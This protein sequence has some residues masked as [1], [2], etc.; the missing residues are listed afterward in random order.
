MIL[1]NLFCGK[2]NKYEK[3]KWIRNLVIAIVILL[4]IGGIIYYVVS[5]AIAQSGDVNIRWSDVV[6]TLQ[7]CAGYIW[8]IGIAV[9]LA[10]VICIACRKLKKQTRFMVRA[11][12][13][14]AAAQDWTIPEPTME[15]Y[16]ENGIFESAEE[17]SDTALI[18]LSRS[19]GE[20]ADL[21]RSITDENTMD[22]GEYG[23]QVVYT[24][25][26]DDVDPPRHYLEL[27]HREEEMVERVTSEFSNVIVIA[28]TNNP[29]E[30]GWGNEADSIKSVLWVAGTGERGFDALGRILNGEVNPSGKLPDTYVY[31]NLAN[32][33]VSNYGDFEYENMSDV[34][35]KE[36]EETWSNDLYASFVNYT[37][38]IYVGYRFY[39][40]AAAEGLID[41]DQTVL[42][43]FGYGLSYTTIDKTISSIET[44]GDTISLTVTV[45]NTGNIAGKD[46]V[47]IYYTPPYYN[48]GIEKSE[49]NLVQFA[50][51]KLLEPQETQNIEISF[52]YEDMASYDYETNGCYVLEHGD[53][54]IS[55]RSD[56]HTVLDSKTVP[57]E[58]DV[59]YNEENAGARSSDQSAAE[60]Q[61]DF[62]EGDITY[63]SRADHFANYVEATAAPD[64][65]NMSDEAKEGFLC[66]ANYNVENYIDGNDTMPVTGED[67]GLTIRDMTGVE[68]DDEKWDLL[69]NE[70]SVDDMINLSINGG[71][72]NQATDSIGM[73]SSTESEGVSRYQEYV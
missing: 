40:T 34:I 68:Y 27:S 20:N 55:L 64:N 21:P 62:A 22:S 10:V 45:T 72:T 42:Y 52:K 19:G 71:Y 25:Q 13:G 53:Y 28:N 7:T 16:D 36:G 46:V 11:Q 44:D 4:I 38:G 48:G 43:P 29:M 2:E 66:T 15:E 56:S 6:Q 70:L 18:V 59:I 8:A 47:E 61:F 17:F 31:D 50:K 5:S 39:E 54:Q 33:A 63:L 37:E 26:S 35:M 1:K 65:F 24:T 9:V 69:L 60:N 14:I 32:P 51:T 30:L 58:E 73:R 67:N 57:V 23:K 49:V 12:A 3:E 41:Y